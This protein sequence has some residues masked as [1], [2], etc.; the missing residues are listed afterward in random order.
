M[1][2]YRLLGLFLSWLDLKCYIPQDAIPGEAVR[3]FLSFGN[4]R[5]EIGMLVVAPLCLYGLICFC[6]RERDTEKNDSAGTMPG[7]EKPARILPTMLTHA[8]SFCLFQYFMWTLDADTMTDVLTWAWKPLLVLLLDFAIV[9]ALGMPKAGEPGRWRRIGLFFAF[10][11]CMIV[12]DILTAGNMWAHNRRVL[13]ITYILGET[14]LIA[15]RM[16]A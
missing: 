1:F 15:E 6:R 7:K 9:R 10:F 4:V 2:C 14:A 8:L 16:I 5:Y 12:L 3:Q 11:L 13:Y